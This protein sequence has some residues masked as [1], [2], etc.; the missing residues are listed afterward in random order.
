MGEGQGTREALGNAARK[1]SPVYG[2]RHVEKV[3]TETRETL[4]RTVETVKSD[5][6]SPKGEVASCEEG[7]GGGCSTDEARTTQ[8]CGGKDPCFVHVLEEV[9]VSECSEIC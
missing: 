8:P 5:P 4:P 1:N 7:G 6:I 3:V 2:D 9:R